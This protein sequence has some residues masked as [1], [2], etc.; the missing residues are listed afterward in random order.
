MVFDFCNLN[1]LLKYLHLFYFGMLEL[2]EQN[3]FLRRISFLS[4]KICLQYFMAVKYVLYI[5][6][7]SFDIQK[8]EKAPLQAQKLASSLLINVPQA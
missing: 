4:F 1:R 3:K 5:W 2:A 7:P 6:I 8:R